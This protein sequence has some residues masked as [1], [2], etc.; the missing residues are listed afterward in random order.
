MAIE[1][2]GERGSRSVCIASRTTSVEIAP[3]AARENLD[4]PSPPPTRRDV[5]RTCNA[6]SAEDQSTGREC[7]RRGGE[8]RGRFSA[9]AYRARHVSSP[10]C[11]VRCRTYSLDPHIDSILKSISF[12]RPDNSES[13]KEREREGGREGGNENR[14]F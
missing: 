8:G 4:F 14:E 2:R 12:A 3:N 11:D 1:K 7:W 9:S 5:R 6:D 13:E 10:A